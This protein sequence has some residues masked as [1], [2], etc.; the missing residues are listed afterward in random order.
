MIKRTNPDVALSSK[1]THFGLSNLS[2]AS[3]IFK[4]YFNAISNVFDN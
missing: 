3:E 2:L 1:E 4:L